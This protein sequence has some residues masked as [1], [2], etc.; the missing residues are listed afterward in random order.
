[1]HDNGDVS[2]AFL[3]VFRALLILKF[4]RYS[5]GLRI[6]GQTL[7]TCMCE[8]GCLVFP[9]AVI[10]LI[11]ATAMFYTEKNVEGTSFTSIPTALWYTIRANDLVIHRVLEIKI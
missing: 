8:L 2:S 5:R 11:F 4:S 7:K 10:S 9:L 1:M 3:R 6:F